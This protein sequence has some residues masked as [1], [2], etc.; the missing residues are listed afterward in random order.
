M[1]GATTPGDRG[2]TCPAAATADVG[3][4]DATAEETAPKPGVAPDDGEHP[5]TKPCEICGHLIP[6]AARKCTECDEWLSR[7]MRLFVVQGKAVVTILPI[8]TLCIGF[9]AQLDGL[10]AERLQGFALRCEAQ[11]QSGT[12]R[13]F[14][15]EALILS[16]LKEPVFLGPLRI[17]QNASLRVFDQQL[18][19]SETT[20]LV[21]SGPLPFTFTIAV[22]TLE[23]VCDAGQDAFAVTATPLSLSASQKPI[24]IAS[25]QC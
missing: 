4:T 8:V 5:E 19:G 16:D 1:N 6:K 21:S 9:I 13:R 18:N 15:G 23:A 24:R 2:P 12:K 20:Q 22:E 7:G 25:C 14:S 11:N 3:G 17:E 10:W